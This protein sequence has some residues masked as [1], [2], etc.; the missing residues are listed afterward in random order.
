MAFNPRNPREKS[1]AASAEMRS[2]FLGLAVHHR[3]IAAPAEPQVGYVWL[4]V[5]DDDNWKLRMYTKN[6][7]A[8]A[9]W[10]VLFEHVESTPAVPVAGL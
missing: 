6:K 5:A 7:T 1:P 2:N 4:D 8:P 3:G 10:V 9:A